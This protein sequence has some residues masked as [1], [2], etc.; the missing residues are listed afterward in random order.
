MV[1]PAWV[2]LLMRSSVNGLG[3]WATCSVQHARGSEHTDVLATMPEAKTG[4]AAFHLGRRHSD[5]V[6]F[7]V[8]RLLA[9]PEGTSACSELSK[10]V[11]GPDPARIRRF[12]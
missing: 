9:K 6:R 2:L 7:V 12:R 4:A 10:G 8:S 5:L 1:G 11:R 3:S